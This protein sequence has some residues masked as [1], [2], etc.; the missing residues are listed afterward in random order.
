MAAAGPVLLAVLVLVSPVAVG[1]PH[2]P[3]AAAKA[4]RSTLGEFLGV[5]TVPH[6]GDVWAYGDAGL[7]SH[8][9]VAR[10]HDGHWQRVKA[11]KLGGRYGQVV[12]IAAGSAGTVWLL[13]G[14]QQK[15]GIQELPAIWRWSGKR[16]IRQHLP[17]LQSGEL[18]VAS[19]DI[20]ASSATNAWVTGG[21]YTPTNPLI[22][23]HWN[24]KKWA[25]VSTPIGAGLGPVATSS[26]TNAWAVGSGTFDHWN[27]MTWSADGTAPTGVQFSAVATSSPKLAYAVGFNTTTYTPVIMRFNGTSWSGAHLSKKAKREDQLEGLTM[28]G[29]TAWAI[30]TSGDRPKILHTTGGAWTIEQSLKSGDYVEGISAKSSKQAFAAGSYVNT[31][32]MARRTYFEFFNGHSWKAQPSKL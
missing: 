7:N 29:R 15:P 3:M 25:Q 22:A 13:G 24:G 20:A 10:R 2:R 32:E 11:P 28:H 14:F 23:L 9:F 6:S 21:L 8:L 30:G 31:I 5:T 12:G 16:F 17:K 4:P 19:S 27:G 26:A 18:E 1:V